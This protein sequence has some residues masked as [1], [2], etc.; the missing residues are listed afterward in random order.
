[1]LVFLL[2]FVLFYFFFSLFLKFIFFSSFLFFN[3]NYFFCVGG[4]GE[5]G[6]KLK[7]YA[8][9]FFLYFCYLIVY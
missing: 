2:V 6:L 4:G 5:T 1:M 9:G 7:Q 3:S 8:S